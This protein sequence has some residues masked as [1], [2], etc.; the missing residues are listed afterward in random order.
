[1]DL[2]L[3]IP[4]GSQFYPLSSFFFIFSETPQEFFVKKLANPRGSN[5]WSFDG[6]INVGVDPT[7]IYGKNTK[8]PIQD[9]IDFCYKTL[10]K[11]DF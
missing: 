5:L 2:T 6:R 11:I 3:E 10:L 8:S 1:M 7:Q 4:R 9:F